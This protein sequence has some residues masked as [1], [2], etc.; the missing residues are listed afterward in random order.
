AATAADADG[1]IAKVEFFEGDNKIGEDTTAPYGISWKP[2]APRSYTLTAKVTDNTGD[3]NT[4]AP[5]NIVFGN[6]PKI[7]FFGNNPTAS[8]GDL[9]IIRRLE[10]KGFQVTAIDDDLSQ[11][12]DADGKV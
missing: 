8:A 10:S 5:V 2:S 12:S 3:T 4:S 7:V 1:T 9:V 6:P 11:T